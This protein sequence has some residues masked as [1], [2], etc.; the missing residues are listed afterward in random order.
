MLEHVPST[1]EHTNGH[2]ARNVRLSLA[3]IDLVEPYV[4]WKPLH[5]F[6]VSDLTVESCHMCGTK[7]LPSANF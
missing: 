5:Q 7:L 6:T 2:V 1:K 3:L 4:L